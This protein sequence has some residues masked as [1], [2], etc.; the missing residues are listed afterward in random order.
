MGFGPSLYF[1]AI[2]RGRRGS[3]GHR[4][5]RK[6]IKA[7]KKAGKRLKRFLKDKKVK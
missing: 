3:S 7:A 6:D 1:E 2:M 4:Q 5:L